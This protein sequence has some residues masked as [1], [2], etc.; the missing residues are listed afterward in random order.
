MLPL[1]VPAALVAAPPPT[2]DKVD[3]ARYMGD[4]FEIARL[5]NPFQRKC[6]ITTARYTLK[7]DLAFEVVNGCVTPEG[8]RLEAKGRAKVVDRATGSRI[9]VTFFWPFYGDYW[10]LDLDPDYRW[11]LVGTPDRKY[12]WVIC[13]TERMEP[14][15]LE[16]VLDKAKRLGFD[17]GPLLW[18]PGADRARAAAG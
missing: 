18:S 12:L 11:A 4:W 15:L 10:I 5:P 14:E 3:L 8:K 2:V 17:L 6:A 1:L 9:K 16:R 13:R 7:E